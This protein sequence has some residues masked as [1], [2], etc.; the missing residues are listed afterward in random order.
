MTIEIR[1]PELE[2]LIRERMSSG[3]FEDV[4]DVI[5][6]AL[7]SS[8]VAM[9]RSAANPRPAGRKNLAEL[10][11]ESPLKGLDLDFERDPDCGRD[12]AL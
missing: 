4:E 3:A 2:A 12:V 11:A 5:M 7:K 9:S 10:F 1:K 6:Q 8:P